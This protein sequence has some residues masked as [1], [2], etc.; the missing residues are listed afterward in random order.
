MS[1]FTRLA[2]LKDLEIISIDESTQYKFLNQLLYKF[3]NV[4]HN[5]LQKSSILESLFKYFLAIFI[6]KPITLL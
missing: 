2:H 4:N 3:S 6:T 5:A 1:E